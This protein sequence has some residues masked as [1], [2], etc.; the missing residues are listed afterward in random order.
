MPTKEEMK[1][2][3]PSRWPPRWE[4]VDIL[5]QDGAHNVKLGHISPLSG[6]MQDFID[7]L[8]SN[9]FVSK[10]QLAEL[11]KSQQDANNVSG[12]DP[13]KH[14]YLL[15]FHIAGYPDNKTAQQFFESYQT[16]PTYG[17][18]A[19]VP[20]ASTGISLG[21]LLEAFA[22]KEL[23][24]EAKKAFDEGIMTLSQSG[25]KLEKGKFLE[26]KALFLIG[27]DGKKICQAVLI[28]NFVITGNVL[29]YAFLPTGDTQIHSASCQMTRRKHKR[30]ERC[31]CGA[32]KNH[33]ECSTLKA[34][35]FIH[36]EEVQSLLAQIFSRLKGDAWVYAG[37]Q[38]SGDGLTQ[39]IKDIE[40]IVNDTFN[41]IAGRNGIVTFTTNGEHGSNSRHYSGNAVDL[42]TKDLA[43]S[44]INRITEML[45][46]K[47]G[48]NYDT[49]YEKGEEPH[50]HIE[51]DPKV[52][53]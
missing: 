27:K 37:D 45:K 17:F 46:S 38:T 28:N 49:I 19:P 25:A 22:P 7:S 9:P 11:I 31:G 41:A 12:F 14:D 42:R 33:P 48:E 39:N 34:E 36:R 47:L 1:K 2:L 18:D 24:E 13:D 5:L 52:N 30:N 8:A 50:I 40:S 51:Y 6:T 10:G 16:A 26:E 20:G 53:K 43:A 35:G 21:D 3:L 15:Y 4:V 29:F 32:C 44:Q 23:V